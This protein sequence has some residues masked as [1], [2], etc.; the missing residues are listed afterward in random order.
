MGLRSFSSSISA[1]ALPKDVSDFP[2]A[3][4][5][6]IEVFQ[7]S[8]LKAPKPNATIPAQVLDAI[9]DDVQIRTTIG[10]HFF[11]VFPWMAVVSR[12]KLYQEIAAPSFA[13]DSDVALLVLCMKLVNERHLIVLEGPRNS[14]Y[15]L[16]KDFYSTVESSGVGSIRLIQAGILIMLYEIGHG[17]SPE[18]YISV[19]RTGRLGQAVGLHD[20]AGVPQLAMEPETWDDM[21]ERRRVWWAVYVLDRYAS[22]RNMTSLSLSLSL[23]LSYIIIGM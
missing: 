14:L 9:G 19:G 16:T 15:E 21:E 18:A 23:S 5:L 13:L 12:K 10:A 1:T 11:S 2:S 8:G 4:F 17:I 22:L 20:T 6:D 7:R 3:F